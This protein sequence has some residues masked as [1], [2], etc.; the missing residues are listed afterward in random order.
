M[1]IKKLQTVN[2]WY[3][4][5]YPQ[6][7]NKDGRKLA[8]FKS[9]CPSGGSDTYMFSHFSHKWKSIQRSPNKAKDSLTVDLPVRCPGL[10]I[11]YLLH[12]PKPDTK[13]CKWRLNK[14]KLPNILKLR[15]N[16]QFFPVV[17]EMGGVSNKNSS[18]H[19]NEKGVPRQLTRKHNQDWCEICGMQ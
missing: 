3:H 13:V 10:H 5:S 7:P 18:L 8:K 16:Y 15:T 4:R 11:Q 12:L 14:I 19:G 17:K 1:Q 9:S 2:R 6:K